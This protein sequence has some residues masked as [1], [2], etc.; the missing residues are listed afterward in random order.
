FSN[1]T[2][3]K[4]STNSISKQLGKDK[5]RKRVNDANSNLKHYKYIFENDNSIVVNLNA[6]QNDYKKY[7]SE[8]DVDNN[9]AIDTNGIIEDTVANQPDTKSNIDNNSIMPPDTNST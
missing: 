2:D 3:W 5:S 7:L 8:K 1:S 6:I 4:V 9:S